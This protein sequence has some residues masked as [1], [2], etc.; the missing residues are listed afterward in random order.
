MDPLLHDKWMDAL[1]AVV[2]RS[3]RQTDVECQLGLS[4]YMVI[5][6]D[7]NRGNADIALV[8]IRRAWEELEENPGFRLTFE[9]QGIIG[10]GVEML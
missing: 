5:L 2:K 6:T 8:R 9:V 3:I 1:S 10:D 4:Q 7:T